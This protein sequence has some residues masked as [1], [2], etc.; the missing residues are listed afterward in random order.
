MCYGLGMV[1]VWGLWHFGWCLV[2]SL[3]RAGASLGVAARRTAQ[4]PKAGKPYSTAL[5]RAA[6]RHAEA[7]A[8]G[9]EGAGRSIGMGL[10]FSSAL[11]AVA[12]VIAARQGPGSGGRAR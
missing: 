1:A 7:L 5:E 3:H 11:I 12:M 8:Q 4:L 10:A 6:L 9:V 2:R